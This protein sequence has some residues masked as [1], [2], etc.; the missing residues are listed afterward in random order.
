MVRR[1]TGTPASSFNPPSA[2][3]P[4]GG[5]KAGSQAENRA[6]R[7][8]L[9][10]RL[11]KLAHAVGFGHARVAKPDPL[12]GMST[13]QCTRLREAALAVL[14]DKNLLKK[15]LVYWPRPSPD[16][17]FTQCHLSDDA[18]SLSLTA[19]P[20]RQALLPVL[21]GALLFCHYNLVF[22]Y[23]GAPNGWL[24]FKGRNSLEFGCWVTE[25][26]LPH[27]LPH[28][29]SVLIAVLRNSFMANR[30]T[31]ATQEAF[32]HYVHRGDLDTARRMLTSGLVSPFGSF[33]NV[34]PLFL[35][36]KKADA[37]SLEKIIKEMN[38]LDCFPGFINTSDGTAE[39]QRLLDYAQARGNRAVIDV[40]KKYGAVTHDIAIEE[41]PARPLARERWLLSGNFQSS[42]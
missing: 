12:A 23:H 42:P 6:S 22:G 21:S 39:A 17:R 31:S 26:V 13:E 14:C 28:H 33:N 2:P 19:K 20:I 32:Q 10:S 7:S 25:Q 9:H 34:K 29:E 41:P 18:A 15:I 8:T 16:S 35:L 36:V 40:L 5:E 30:I 27:R 1:L 11:R 24:K 38:D 4:A 37:A 3:Q